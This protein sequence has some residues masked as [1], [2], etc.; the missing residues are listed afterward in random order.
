MYPPPQVSYPPISQQFG[1]LTA[2]PAYNYQPPPQSYNGPP[3]AQQQ[4]SNPGYQQAP[5]NSYPQSNGPPQFGNTGY[6]NPQQYAPTPPI[7]YQQG[8][9]PY[10]P[11][12]NSYSGP[13]PV[14][15]QPP[16]WANGTPTSSH[17]ASP[18]SQQQNM[19]QAHSGYGREFSR[20]PSQQSVPQRQQTPRDT[21]QQQYASDAHQAITQTQNS[22]SNPSQTFAPTNQSLQSAQQLSSLPAGPKLSSHANTPQPRRESTASSQQKERR[23]SATSSVNV[24]ED[25]NV[26]MENGV[27]ED[28]ELTEEDLH[29]QEFEWELKMV[30]FEQPPTENVRL[31]QPLS[32]T[33]ESTPVPLLD[34]RLNNS[35]SRYA[36]KDNLKDFMRPIRSQPQW[37]YLKDDPAFSESSLDDELL[38]PF[39]EVPAWMAARHGIELPNSNRPSSS[40]KRARDEEENEQDDIDNRIKL[41][42][43]TEHLSPQVSSKRQKN[44]EVV[45]KDT[46]IVQVSSTPTG[47]PGTPTLEKV[48]TPSFDAEDDVWAP[49]PGE[50]AS[51]SVDPTEALLAS[52]GVSGNPKPVRK[53]SIPPLQVNEPVHDTSPYSGVP[54]SISPRASQTPDSRNM[55]QQANSGYTNPPHGSQQFNPAYSNPSDGFASQVQY[56]DDMSQQD[57]S[58]PSQQYKPPP[59]NPYGNG[60]SPSASGS[61]NNQQ[62]GMPRQDLYN[63]V[64]S[65]GSQPPQHYGV[66]SQNSFSNPT[67]QDVPVYNNQGVSP[68]GQYP[69]QNHYGFP[70][71]NTPYASY[72]QQAR[73]PNPPYGNPSYNMP[74]QQYPPQNQYNGM[75]MNNGAPY[76]QS[77][78]PYPYLPNNDPYPPANTPYGNPNY[79]VRP[80]GASQHGLPTYPPYSTNPQNFQQ[81]PRQDSGYVSARG[82]YSTGSGAVKNNSTMPTQEQRPEPTRVQSYGTLDGSNDA[83]TPPPA[84]PGEMSFFANL[85]S[86]FPQ[87]GQSKAP[88][89][90]LEKVKTDGISSEEAENDE[91]PLSPTSLEILGRLIPEGDKKESRKVKRPQPVVASAYR[92]VHLIFALQSFKTVLL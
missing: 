47:R 21:S 9:S 46:I 26:K 20:T 54:K 91:S 23:P 27:Y 56:S 37:S 60:T 77:N 33:W 36:R 66:P 35:V 15:G 88:K 61:Y 17:S 29:E 71:A 8:A 89:V 72:P 11:Q 92:Y 1:P 5:E 44:E 75:P 25:A 80:N 81:P 74:P 82:S 43:V 6:E 7:S 69:P 52:L 24:R 2:T 4:Y 41:E 40:R 3:A 48:G 53:G 64:P 78:G 76:A 45:D 86:Q 30:F 90:K 73:P 87:K 70:Q 51:A 85:P 38:I 58:Y 49:Q 67:P 50:G 12:N 39:D 83:T 55:P 84:E 10:V 19:S 32:T 79:G 62:F 18:F 57:N 13:S 59:Q 68:Q 63:N 22:L 65:Q 42:I 16:Q 28:G 14:Q 34:P 31:A